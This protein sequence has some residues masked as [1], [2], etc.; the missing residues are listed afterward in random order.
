MRTMIPSVFI[1]VLWGTAPSL[2][3]LPPE[4]QADSYLLR[5]EQAI[6]EGDQARARAEIDKIILLEK[7]HELDLPDEFH[8]RYAK[9]A[10][11]V[12]LPEQTLE[13][14]EKYL[15]TA[16]REGR[17]Y[18]EA[19]ELM[20]RAQDEIEGREEPQEAS[21][22]PSSPAQEPSRVEPSKVPQLPPS[23]TTEGAKKAVV[24]YPP[25]PKV[26]QLSPGFPEEGAKE[27][28]DLIPQPDVKPEPPSNRARRQA[29]T[30]AA[31]C[32]L[33]RNNNSYKFFE[34]ANLE[35]VM[36]CLDAGANPNARYKG[37]GLTP[38]HWAAKFSE[39]PEIIKVLLAAGADVGAQSSKSDG[40][41][42]PLHT[43]ARFNENAEIIRALVAAGASLEARDKWKYTPLHRASRYNGNPEVIEVLTAAGARVEEWDA[44]GNPPLYYAARDNGNPA[45]IE[46]LLKAGAKPLGGFMVD[47]QYAAA[48]YNRN[49]AVLGALFKASPKVRAGLKW[50]GLHQ[51]VAFNETPGA[52][53]ALLKA[54]ADPRAQDK[55]K[56]TPLH[57]AVRDNGNP[58]VIEALLKAGADRGRR[59]GPTK[60]PL[61]TMR[62][63]TIGIR[64]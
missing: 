20:N 18:V 32:T 17:H 37:T 23:F 38:L 43:A 22:K 63:A 51:A 57:Y 62:P 21:N 29:T 14:I 26:P 40:R 8:F 55:Y 6:G 2:A 30:Q 45:V 5:A 52:I 13:A 44:A 60:G 12:D 4:I 36:A 61:C 27:A 46:A 15:L 24:R 39:Q 31:D 49:P 10:A 19:L 33:W 53:E 34:T 50:S 47:P 25:P 58:A 1:L 41:N 3:Q 54:G 56:L 28:V 35:D 42:T 64:P 11:A 59:T 9:A 16:G 48:Y 7:E